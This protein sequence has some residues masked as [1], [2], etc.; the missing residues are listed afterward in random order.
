MGS[1][2]QPKFSR[3]DAGNAE[4]FAW[5]SKEDLRYDH[6]RGIWLVWRGHWWSVDTDELVMRRAKSIARMR[7]QAAHRL[8]G[9][10]K[11]GELSW[12]HMSELRAHLEAM[13]SLAKSEYPLYVSSGWDAE[14]Y[15]LGV[16]NG[17]VDLRVGLLR[18]GR[19]SDLIT[20]HTDIPFDARTPCPRWLQFLHEVFG[21]DQAIVQYIQRAIGYCLTGDV[22]EQCLFLC[23]GTGANGKSTFLEVLRR[24][25]GDYAYNLPFS[26]FELKARSSIPN[27][28]AAIAGKR[29]VTA[30]ETN[31]SAQLNEARIKMLTGCDPVTARLLHH[32]FFVFSSTG[33]VWLA[34]NHLPDV[35]DDSHGLWRRIRLIPFLQ[36]F[37]ED[38]ADKDLLAKLLAEAPGILAWAVQGCLMWQAEGLNSPPIVQE[39]TDAYK[40]ESDP[41]EDF[42]IERCVVAPSARVTAAALWDAYLN[43]A[44]DNMERA[45]L[46]RKGFSR[47]L[48]AKGFKKARQGHTRDWTW[49]G[50]GLKIDNR[51]FQDPRAAMRTD[52]DVNFPIVS[53]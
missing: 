50:I 6:R 47:R 35:G 37:D 4:M 36:R 49:L 38:A 30:I 16:A 24:M 19:Q 14:Q 10:D 53:S 33:K 52:A 34:F 15:L 22:R 3:T 5:A 45:P 31:E 43:W 12:A 18:E 46:D 28:I 32:E 13:I 11:E 29:L 20:L 2:R 21:G 26:A 39:R 42:I 17:V 40:R 9:D 1:H 25:L 27:D 8:S 48:E 7:A 23:H 51:G 44:S 41:L